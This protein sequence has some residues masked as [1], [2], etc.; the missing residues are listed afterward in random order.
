MAAFHGSR[1]PTMLHDLGPGTRLG[2]ACA[3]ALSLPTSAA[4]STTPFLTDGAVTAIVNSSSTVY[5]GGVFS[6]VS[7]A[8]IGEAATINTT[9]AARAAGVAEVT[10]GLVSAMVPDGSGGW[11]LGGTFTFVGGSPRSGLAHI[12]ASG[13]LDTGF[14]PSLTGSV[15]ALAL[16]SGTL[17]VGGTFHMG[18]HTDLVALR[19]GTGAVQTNVTASVNGPV[20]ALLRS[21]GTLYVGGS[22]TQLDSAAHAGLGAIAAG[23]GQPVSGFDSSV[24]VNA[25]IAVSALAISGSNLYLG[26]NFGTVDSSSRNGL[27][28]VDKSTGALDGAFTPDIASGGA[29][30]ALAIGSSGPLYVGGQW[31]DSISHFHN[32]AALDANSGAGDPS[33]TVAL[34]PSDVLTPAS[35]ASLLL[36]GS[37]LYV[38]GSFAKVNLT[39]AYNLAAVSP[40]TG[41]LISGWHPNPGGRIDAL[42]LVGTKLEAGG[43]VRFLGGTPRHSL[44]ALNISNGSLV[45]SFAP[46][47]GTYVFSLLLSGGTLY[48]GGGIPGGLA[49]VH[50]SNGSPVAGFAS[51]LNGYVNT[52]VM[53]GGT[54]YVGG[55]LTDGMDRNLAALNPATGGTDSTFSAQAGSP[56]SFVVSLDVS[57]GTL[58]AGGEFTTLDGVTRN[59]IGAVSATDGSLITGFNPNANRIV[60][61]LAISGGE[62]F[63]GGGFTS[64]GSTSTTAVAAVSP[65]S[66][67]TNGAFTPTFDA[68][69]Q[70]MIVSGTTLYAAGPFTLVDGKRRSELVALN[71][72]DGSLSSSTPPGAASVVVSTALGNWPYALRKIGSSIFVGGAFLSLGAHPAGGFGSFPG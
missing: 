38:G 45:S 71:T 31:D 27:A 29:I 35:V 12:K 26:G 62:L 33:F 67:I 47:V 19:A 1:S 30:H 13:L 11:Y 51:P 15:A 46:N 70:T 9:T 5:L 72:S 2:L 40:S 3:L 65:S 22:F 60:N 55:A 28:A 14:H 20:D 50:A 34:S 69:V 64:I 10:G 56:G 23:N 41:S 48:V 54:L 42:T 52:M 59:F 32:V 39:Q 4:A 49:A 63:I 6:R 21:G 58:Y 37:R 36:S 16:S 43:D 24:G 18:T 53:S 66:G 17:Y 7:S 57:G 25:Q 44:A 8:P 61:T 68:A